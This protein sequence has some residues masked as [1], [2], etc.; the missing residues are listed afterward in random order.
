MVC[1]PHGYPTIPGIAKYLPCPGSP[2]IS[3]GGTRL[4]TW[5][6]AVS[7]HPAEDLAE[8]ARGPRDLPTEEWLDWIQGRTTALP[9]TAAMLLACKQML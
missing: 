8:S 2:N 1:G 4:V 5:P 3:P 6:S 7:L 9:V